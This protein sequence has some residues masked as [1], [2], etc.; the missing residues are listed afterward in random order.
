MKLKRS[1][2]VIGDMHVGS[3]FAVFPPDFKTEKGNPIHMNPGQEKIYAYWLK[4][5]KILNDWNVDTI[6][7][8]GD[9]IQGL[10]WK[11]A[12]MFNI[13]PELD[14]QKRATDI[15]L[16]PIC[17][18]REVIGVSGTKYHDARDI[19]L[20]KDIIKELKGKYYGYVINGD[21]T[22]TKRTMN[23]MHG[24][25]KALVYRETSASRETLF[26]KEAEALE[27]LFKCDILLRAHNHF[28]LHIHRLKS[29]YILNP[30]WQALVP[31]DY[32]MANY[33]KWQP[34]IGFSIITIDYEDRINVMHFCME[35]QIHV[36]DYVRKI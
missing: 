26:F 35:E 36:T 11:R 15:L 10:H 6:I 19:E 7:L 33:A 5:R 4:G 27:K 34:D 13:L 9:L 21:V 2:G 23:I 31:D 14:E 3:A 24:K 25:S 1:F 30:C 22:G 32:T 8:I 12:G 16:K 18:D 20:E 28:F 17:K 29:H